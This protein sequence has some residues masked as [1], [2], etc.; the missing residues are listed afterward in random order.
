MVVVL[1]AVG[2]LSGGF[3]LCSL[4]SLEPCGLERHI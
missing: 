3:A 2:A 4:D 1:V